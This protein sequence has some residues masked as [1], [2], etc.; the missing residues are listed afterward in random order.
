M[1][2]PQVDIGLS[3][4]GGGGVGTNE[5]FGLTPTCTVATPLGGAHGEVGVGDGASLYG[6]AAIPGVLKADAVWR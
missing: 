1:S 4:S 5:G 3:G 2:L 6:G